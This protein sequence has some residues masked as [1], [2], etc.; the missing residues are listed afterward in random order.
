MKKTAF[1]G[2]H[3]LAYRWNEAIY[4]VKSQP[5]EEI[6]VYKVVKEEGTEEKC[7]HHNLLLPV[8]ALTLEDLKEVNEPRVSLPKKSHFLVEW[9]TLLLRGRRLRKKMMRK[10]I[11]LNME[12][13]KAL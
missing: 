7:L 10:T 1:K 12:K 13:L 5:N 9:N 8:A 3:K 6:P 2:K 4:I 11:C